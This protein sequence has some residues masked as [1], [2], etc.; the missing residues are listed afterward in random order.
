MRRIKKVSGK[1][2]NILWAWTWNK[3]T[4]NSVPTAY[5]FGYINIYLLQGCLVIFIP[6][7]YWS[8]EKDFP[9]IENEKLIK[10]NNS[11]Q[12]KSSLTHFK[13]PVAATLRAENM[14]K[15]RVPYQLWKQAANCSSILYLAGSKFLYLN[16]WFNISGWKSYDT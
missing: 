11:S 14:E 9:L 15:S 4:N 6:L 8:Y 1:S 10:L 16:I 13:F 5:V 3:N 12:V 2:L 7:I